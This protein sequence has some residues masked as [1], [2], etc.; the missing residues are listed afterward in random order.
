[1]RKPDLDTILTAVEAFNPP[2]GE[3][4][5]QLKDSQTLMNLVEA[6]IPLARALYYLTCAGYRITHA[7]AETCTMEKL[8][9]PKL[10]DLDALY[11]SVERFRAIA[12]VFTQDQGFQIPTDQPLRVLLLGFLRKSGFT[13][14]TIAE[15][16]T[17]IAI[18]RYRITTERPEAQIWDRVNVLI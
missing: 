3:F 15:F 6:D 12:K 5:L 7:T 8:A 11:T 9:D 13:E 10:L 16:T 1:M 4:T 17:M 2:D 14:G 18:L